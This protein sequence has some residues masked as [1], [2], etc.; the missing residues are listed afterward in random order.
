ML[1]R[2]TISGLRV[3]GYHGVLPH[4]RSAGQDFFIDA[5]LWLDTAPAAAADDLRLTADYGAIA[6]RLAAIVAGEPVD[7]IETLADRLAAAC[8]AASPVQGAEVTVHKPQAPV[9]Q[10]VADIAVTVRRGRT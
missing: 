4:E 2:I 9:G 7:L 1:D 8:L 6:D 5:V 3:R 10:E